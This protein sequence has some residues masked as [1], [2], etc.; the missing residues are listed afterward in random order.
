MLLRAPCVTGRVGNAFGHDVDGEAIASN[1]GILRQ[2]PDAQSRLVPD[3]TAVRY[4]RA[5]DD[6]KKRGLACAVPSD[7]ADAF[8][9][10]DPKA[11][12]VEQWEMAI[13][14]RDLV[15]RNERHPPGS[16]HPDDL[17]LLQPGIYGRQTRPTVSCL[18]T[19]ERSS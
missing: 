11:G 10:F 8:A 4:E 1:E 14:H 12:L 3:G 19:S 6:L 5:A 16:Y 13:G 15:E 17:D 7:H 9:R 2:P 18:D